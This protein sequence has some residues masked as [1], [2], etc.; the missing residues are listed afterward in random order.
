MSLFTQSKSQPA[1]ATTPGDFLLRLSDTCHPRAFSSVV[2]REYLCPALDALPVDQRANLFAILQEAERATVDVSSHFGR[3]DLS[4]EDSDGDYDTGSD[5][6]CVVDPTEP[7][8]V[9]LTERKRRVEA[10]IRADVTSTPEFDE[11]VLSWLPIL[12]HLGVEGATNTG[13]ILTAL[14]LCDAIRYVT[15][16]AT[17]FPLPDPH[18]FTASPRC[19][20]SLDCTIVN[21]KRIPVYSNTGSLS[22]HVG[23]IRR[24]L[25]LKKAS[26]GDISRVLPMLSEL[27]GRDLQRIAQWLPG[28]TLVDGKSLIRISAFTLQSNF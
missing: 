17:G 12:W 10:L 24:E 9:Q 3:L 21:I 18:G 22:E 6:D 25:L 19:S 23:W 16:A 2:L 13:E 1:A 27:Q 14:Q 11:E 28:S 15:Y 26:S 7:A 20:S 8:N 5:D 4:C